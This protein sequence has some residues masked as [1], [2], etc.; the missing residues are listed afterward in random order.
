MKRIIFVL[1]LIICNLSINAQE[2]RFD[3][4]KFR[5]DLHK[6]IVSEAHLTQAEADKFFPLYDEMKNK[7]RS[8]HRQIR[9]LIR[10]KPSSDAA[11]RTAIVKRDGI[12]VQM[13]QLES[14]YHEKFLKVISPSKLYD[15]LDAEGRFHR[16][17]F[18][19]TIRKGR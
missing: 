3:Y 17:T 13:K 10:Q 5:I 14:K 8:L 15:V 1:A 6:Y 2:K 16:Q 18:E 11:C 9:A 19:K 4:V 12:E 7:Q